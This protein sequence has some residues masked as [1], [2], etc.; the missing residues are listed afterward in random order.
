MISL[1]QSLT[2]NKTYQ[3]YAIYNGQRHLTSLTHPAEDAE[4]S[5]QA[6]YKAWLWP[7]MQQP[8]SAIYKELAHLAQL[9][10]NGKRV[11]I[12]THENTQHGAVIVA[13][14]KT[15]AHNLAKVEINES[16]SH[17]GL[18]TW[19][20]NAADR[21]LIDERRFIWYTTR[22][23][24]RAYLGYVWD[25]EGVITALIPTFGLV[26]LSRLTGNQS[27]WQRRYRKQLDEGI[28]TAQVKL[29]REVERTF[30]RMIKKQQE[31]ERSEPLVV[32]YPFG[33]RHTAEAR[34]QDLPWATHDEEQA[35]EEEPSAEEQ[36][37]TT[38]TEAFFN[39][40][41]ALQPEHFF[42]YEPTKYQGEHVKPVIKTKR[43][44]SQWVLTPAMQARGALHLYQPLK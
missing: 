29:T 16:S 43:D 27:F 4:A 33:L 24:K 1:S 23:G 19:Q 32:T 20:E 6:E 10:R 25:T 35:F 39:L 28:H 40:F 14:I 30:A 38:E 37:A 11:V 8:H 41:A 42:K 3:V 21:D 36:M 9:H 44:G 2:N 15:L 26:K 12:V 22:P 17:A 18:N 34:W 7:F 13:A 31:K 5:P